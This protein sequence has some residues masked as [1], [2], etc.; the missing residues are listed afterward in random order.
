MSSSTPRL[1]RLPEVRSV[2]GL[3]RSMIYLLEAQQKFPRR[4][5]ISLRAVGWPE[6]EVRQWVSLRIA[7]R[8]S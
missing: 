2:T 8:S 1:L 7:N 5:K 6:D 3:S 4:V